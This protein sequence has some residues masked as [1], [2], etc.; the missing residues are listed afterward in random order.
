MLSMNWLIIGGLV[1]AAAALL[2]LGALTGGGKP[3][4]TGYQKRDFLF[5]PEERLFLVALKEAVGE[6]YEVFGKV[7]ASD[8]LSP[9]PHSARGNAAEDH[10]LLAERSFAFLLCSKPDLS[11]ACAVELHDHAIPGKKPQP[12]APDTLKAACFAAGLPLVPFE[13]GPWYAPHEI[14]EAIAQAVRKE[15][16][17]LTE[18]DGRKEP[19]ISRLDNLD[20]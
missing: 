2:A 18:S 11:V 16:V 5:S 4:K 10:P 15:P 14:K 6:D 3:S 12:Q 8:I 17:Y 20:L 9:R 7:R 13:V 1:L 19:R